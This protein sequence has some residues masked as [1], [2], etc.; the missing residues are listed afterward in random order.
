MRELIARYLLRAMKARW[1]DQRA[2]LGALAGALRPGETAVDAGANKGAYLFWLAKAV[3]PGGR[4]VAFEPQPALAEYLREVARRLRWRH[5]EVRQAGL[6]DRSGKADL[7][8]PEGETSPGASFE[9]RAGAPPGS[10]RKVEC[11]VETL[12]HN[13]AGGPRVGA[14]KIDV[15]GHELAVLRGAEAVLARDHPTLLVECEARHLSTHTV[16]EVLD[17]LLARGYRGR[18]FH[19]EGLKDL[20]QFDVAK[21]Q[22]RDGDRFWD[23][24]GYCNNFLFEAS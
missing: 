9:P 19:P 10:G 4:V 20:D 21:H 1:R 14:M 22:K 17:H 23:A 16:R 24:P 12:D 6:S 2:E 13:L 18:F 11:P 8:V 7:F 15:E 3:G 5:V